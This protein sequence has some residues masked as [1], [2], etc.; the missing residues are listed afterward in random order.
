M[1]VSLEGTERKT[2]TGVDF[3]F[4]PCSRGC[5]ARRSIGYFIIVRLIFVSILVLVDVSLE[6]PVC[7]QHGIKGLCFNP[8]SR[9]CFARRRLNS[10]MVTVLL[11]VSILV[12]VDVSLEVHRLPDLFLLSECFNPCSRGCFA[13]SRCCISSIR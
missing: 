6:V 11:F 10:L 8:C 12:L 2:S 3:G 4:N 1:D 5:F 9:G 7:F 13:R